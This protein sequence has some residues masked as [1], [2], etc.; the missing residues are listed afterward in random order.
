M[1]GVAEEALA[2]AAVRAPSRVAEEAAAAGRRQVRLEM[3]RRLMDE[4]AAQAR[5]Q[6]RRPASARTTRRPRSEGQQQ[7]AAG[8]EVQPQP[9]P[10]PRSAGRLSRASPPSVS[11]ASPPSVNPRPASVSRA[12]PRPASANRV[13]RPST[14]VAAPR[15]PSAPRAPRSESRSGVPSR[16]VA[17]DEGT[18]QVKRA[19]KTLCKEL[20]L[21]DWQP[22]LMEALKTMHKHQKHLAGKAGCRG[23]NG[24][25]Q[26]AEAVIRGSLKSK[27]ILLPHPD[28]GGSY[29]R[30]GVDAPLVPLE[31]ALKYARQSPSCVR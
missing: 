3:E 19:L 22:E 12:S 11:R 26:Q 31:L 18:A 14:P 8:G 1:E 21:E 16:F 25:F 24:P 5:L 10:R 29:R 6:R 23:T 27:G 17:S 13:R 30:Q 7:A 4:H 2:S 15:A 28:I 9:Q 20:S